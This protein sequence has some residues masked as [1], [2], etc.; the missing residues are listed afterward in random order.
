MSPVFENL[1][2]LVFY[3]YVG[4][5]FRPAGDN[6]YMEVHRDDVATDE[7]RAAMHAPG[8]L[9]TPC[10]G[11]HAC[12]SQDF[13]LSEGGAGTGIEMAKRTPSSAV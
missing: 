13:G 1:A 4:Y 3:V 6:P 5:K 12:A 2:T 10:Y 9:R 11:Y 8:W 7:V